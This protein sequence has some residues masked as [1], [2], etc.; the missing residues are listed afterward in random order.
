MR[1][2]RGFHTAVAA[3]TT[4]LILAAT[5]AALSA[6]MQDAP[7]TRVKLGFDNETP[8]K[9]VAIALLLDV[10]TGAEVGSTIAEVSFPRKLLTFQQIK[11]GVIAQA[12]GAEVRGVLKKDD[13]AK[14]ISVIT[15]TA[16]AKKGSSLSTGALAD[17]VFKIAGDAPVGETVDLNL[18]AKAF[19]VG[20]ASRPVTPVAV[21]DGAIRV[22]K[23]APDSTCYFYMH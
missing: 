21:E 3:G 19:A 23:F 13:P 9:E 10:T 2:A 4:A 20:D 22:T 18:S 14:D 17:L 15:I 11:P 5:T 6:A 12:E 8:G 1:W 7:V 16:T